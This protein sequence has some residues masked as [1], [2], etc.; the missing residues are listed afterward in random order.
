[1]D[2]LKNAL[3]NAVGGAALPAG[4]PSPA[5]PEPAPT[6]PDP[7]T[8]EWGQLLR[9][10]GVEIPRDPTMGQLTQRS[11][12]RTRELVAAGRKR[13]GQS[14]KEAKERYLREREK[15]AWGHV[16]DRFEALA[17]PEKA[18]RSLKQEGTDPERILA[19]LRGKKGEELRGGGAARVRDALKDAG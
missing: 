2:Q 15:T 10:L 8:S 13:E 17:L 1:M 14:L 12:A 7:L 4:A 9:Q 5:A 19:R 18:Y 11:D 6:L 16:K 3:Q